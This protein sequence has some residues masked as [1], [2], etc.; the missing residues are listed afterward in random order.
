MTDFHEPAAMGILLCFRIPV[1]GHRQTRHELMHHMSMGSA[2]GLRTHKRAIS[3]R[4]CLE[5]LKV[6]GQ[7]PDIIHAHE[8]QLSA[9]PMLYWCALARSET[10]VHARGMEDVLMVTAS[11]A[12]A[13]SRT[14]CLEPLF[15][16]CEQCLAVQEPGQVGN[17]CREAYHGEGLDRSRVMLTIHNMDNSGECRQDEFAFTGKP[18]SLG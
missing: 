2:T 12:T 10:A 16:F 7:Q 3:C 8:W 14:D 11:C 18:S 6:S 17:A 13:L 9:V 1:T 4:A 15:T 5:Y